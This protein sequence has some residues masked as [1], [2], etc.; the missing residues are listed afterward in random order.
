M[1]DNPALDQIVAFFEADVL[2]L[3]TCHPNKYELDIEDFEGVLKTT[4]AYYYELESSGRLNEYIL[5][6]RFGYHKKRMAPYVLEF[7]FQI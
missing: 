5:Q 2:N 3:Y 6:I 1:P 4:E 7:S